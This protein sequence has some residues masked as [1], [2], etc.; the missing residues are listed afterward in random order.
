MNKEPITFYIFRLLLSLS[1]LVLVIMLYWSSLLVEDNTLSIRSN[2][3][4]LQQEVS[5]LKIEIIQIEQTIKHADLTHEH[6]IITSPSSSKKAS[7]SPSHIHPLFPNLLHE[8][9]FYSQTLPK[10]LGPHFKPRGTFHSSVLGK[11][12]NLHPFSNFVAAS[13]F[14]SLCS[15]A[16]SKL[17][18]GKYETMAPDMAIK[19]E[20]RINPTTQK[21]EFWI[22]LKEGVYWQPLNNNL[23][24]EDIHLAPHFFQKHPVTAHDFKFW[25]DALMNPYNQEMGAIADRIYLNDIE[26]IEVLDNLTL[27][28]RWK[29]HEVVVDG[30]KKQ[31]M[32]YLAKS[33]TGALRP[34]ASFVYKYFPD[35][36]KILE[37]D[38]DPNAYRTSSVWAPLDFRGHDRPANFF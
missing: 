28:V 13:Q 37:E 31:L 23:F 20:Q 2:I 3:E 18:F 24:S 25:F 38:S 12:D 29:T 17:E 7:T 14:I 26:E 35:G 8:D 36:K 22:Q 16:A 11:P 9:L 10:L 15:L 21:P 1:L 19:I 4:Q 6:P 30:E 27:I 33:W 34:L 5:H 32:K